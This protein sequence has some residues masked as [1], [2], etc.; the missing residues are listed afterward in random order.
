MNHLIEAH[1]KSLVHISNSAIYQRLS[2]AHS[3][4]RASKRKEKKMKGRD[5]LPRVDSH[6]EA[7]TEQH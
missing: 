7:S 4:E 5:L 1:V 6:P 2:Q 3:Q